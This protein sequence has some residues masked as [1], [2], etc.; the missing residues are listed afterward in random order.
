[1]SF[2]P[3]PGDFGV[4]KGGGAIMAFVRLGTF[5]RYGHACVAESVHQSGQIT[6]I[7][8]MPSG[9]RRRVARPGEFVW[10]DIPL[11]DEQ[12]AEV[13]AYAAGCL[14]AGYDWPAI[15]GFVLRWWAHRL[16][17]WRR[18]RHASPAGR[19]ARATDPEAGTLICSE[20]PVLA[21]RRVGVDMAPGK[22]AGAVS[23]GDL[24]QWLDDQ[25][26]AARR[27]EPPPAWG[28]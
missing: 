9:C 13:V 10:S 15:R 12:R 2:V 6:V 8:P 20:L 14:G 21:Y 22:P 18:P 3:S 11:S 1:M 5:S 24:R 4:A 27:P 25:R 26:R 23:P 16:T 17:P 7:E 19:G 28:Q